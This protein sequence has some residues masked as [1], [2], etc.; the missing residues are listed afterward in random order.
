MSRLLLIDDEQ[1]VRYSFRR[2]F[3]ADADVA[4]FGHC[5]GYQR[6]H[7]D[8][9]AGDHP[10]RVWRCV[11]QQRE[12]GGKAKRLWRKTKSKSVAPIMIRV[13]LATGSCPARM[14]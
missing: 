10:G 13:R 11:P 12:M 6:R 3:E 2:V 4:A 1:S 7:V 14:R 5:C 9:E 8:A